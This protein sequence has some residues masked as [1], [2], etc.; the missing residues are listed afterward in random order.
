MYSPFGIF[1][2]Y[3]MIRLN[4]NSPTISPRCTAVERSDEENLLVVNSDIG[5]IGLKLGFT[6][7]KYSSVAIRANEKLNQRSTGTTNC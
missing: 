2:P 3:G 6:V 5:W 7:A 1:N 4:R